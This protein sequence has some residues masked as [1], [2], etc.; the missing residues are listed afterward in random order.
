M[1]E[2]W[3]EGASIVESGELVVVVDETAEA[4]RSMTAR[5]LDKCYRLAWAI[6]GDAQEA[7]DA[8]QDAFASAW[9]NR[10][11]LR[12]VDKLEAWL[13]RTLVNTCRDR[14]RQRSRNR[15]APLEQW[16]LPPVSDHSEAASSRDEMDRALASLD[17][18]HRIVVILRF[19]ADMTV[20]EIAQRVGVAEGTVKSRLHYSMRVLRATLEDVR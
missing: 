4:F 12:D 13:G 2:A 8:T 3:V 17:P 5:Q 14:L 1:S 9:H 10:H 6:L 15:A 16:S 7:E 11:R 18:D 20:E 19:W